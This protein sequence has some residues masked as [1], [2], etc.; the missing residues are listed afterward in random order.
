M[1]NGKRGPTSPRIT[2]E[3]LIVDFI[4]C[5]CRMRC[6][7]SV[8]RSKN[9]INSMIVDKPIQKHFIEW[10]KTNSHISGDLMNNGEDFSREI[11]IC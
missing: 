2:I 4:I 3:H 8:G 7:L 9:L 5:L 6:P 1:T 10:K 11:S